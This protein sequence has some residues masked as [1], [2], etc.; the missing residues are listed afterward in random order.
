MPKLNSPLAS[1]NRSGFTLVELLIVIGIIAVLAGIIFPVFAK[2]R[3][4]ARSTKCQSNLKQI[5]QALEMYAA[6]WDQRLPD[7]QPCY[8]LSDCTKNEAA[9]WKPSKS[10]SERKTALELSWEGALIPYTKS[11]DVFTC[12]SQPEL[13]YEQGKSGYAYNGTFWSGVQSP[14][15]GIVGTADS[16]SGLDGYRKVTSIEDPGN[17]I[18][19][20][21]SPSTGKPEIDGGDDTTGKLCPSQ[22][23]D[24]EKP[25]ARHN[26]GFNALFADGKVKWLRS[27]QDYQF[28]IEKDT[29]ADITCP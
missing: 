19:V 11:W 1:M 13:C 2:A 29:T 6:D 25:H 16:T 26:S 22:Y 14:C 18:M 21:D 4:K 12:P 10:L 27:F 28:T 17:T 3:E 5:G 7:S 8:W 24:D 23:P 15:G 20:T 9:E